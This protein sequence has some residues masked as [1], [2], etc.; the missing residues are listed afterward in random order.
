MRW[1]IWDSVL[2]FFY[3]PGPSQKFF[4][5]QTFFEPK[6]VSTVLLLQVESDI[7]DDFIVVFGDNLIDASSLQQIIDI[8]HSNALLITSHDQPSNYGVVDVKGLEPGEKKI[9]HLRNRL[10]GRLVQ[11]AIHR[12]GTGRVP[13]GVLGQILGATRLEDCGNMRQ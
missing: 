1:E 5:K 9:I 3:L 13:N 2:S 10:P 8:P 4:L 7:N 12:D 11:E 6:S